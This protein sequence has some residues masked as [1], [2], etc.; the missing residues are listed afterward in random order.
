MI[1]EFLASYSKTEV[2]KKLS[3]KFTGNASCISYFF[4]MVY[5]IF[6][7]I[8]SLYLLLIMVSNFF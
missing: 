4:G 1:N 7:I 6:G 3:V 5:L 2:V 8:L